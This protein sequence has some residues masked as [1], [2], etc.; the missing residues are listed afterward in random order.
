MDVLKEL[1][2]GL[3]DKQI[4]DALDI[5]EYTARDHLKNIRAKLRVADRTEAVT[6]ALQRGIIHL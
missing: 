4:A 5:T 1:A 2:K 6:V 3:G